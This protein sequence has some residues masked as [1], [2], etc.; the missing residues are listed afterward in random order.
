M[1]QGYFNLETTPLGSRLKRKLLAAA[2]VQ[3][4]SSTSSTSTEV[5][6]SRAEGGGRFQN[7]FHSML[8]IL[9]GESPLE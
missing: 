4:A 3:A 6:G 8:H 7:D 1:L 2:H 9:V 5:G